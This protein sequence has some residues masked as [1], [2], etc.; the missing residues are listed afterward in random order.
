MA[1]MEEGISSYAEFTISRFSVYLS[2][3]HH[4]FFAT[5]NPRKEFD[6]HFQL[7]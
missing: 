1:L 6:H 3:F 4:F 5:S 2:Q 7:L